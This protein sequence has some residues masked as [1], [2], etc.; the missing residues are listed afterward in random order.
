RQS[1]WVLERDCSMLAALA[2]IDDPP[3]PAW[4]RLFTFKPLLSR[5][6]TWQALFEKVR[7]R[8]QA[9][10][11]PFIAALPLYDWFE[12]LLYQSGFTQ[13]QAII[14]LEWCQKNT[15][16]SKPE[17]NFTIRPLLPQDLPYAHAV[18]CAA[19]DPLWRISIDTLTHAYH[20]SA[21]ATVAERE[22]KVLGFQISTAKTASAHLARLAVQPGQQQRGVGTFLLHNMQEHFNRQ[23]IND[24]TV[25][26]QN[27]NEASIALYQK[28][29]YKQTGERFPVM[30]YP[31][32]ADLAAAQK[33]LR[34][35]DTQR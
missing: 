26:T 15:S 31:I 6:E 30:V 9:D 20:H 24:L 17:A 1:F 21:Y 16:S 29:G 3:E 32:Q 2:C 18:D 19:F 7:Q 34:Q 27:D 25:N 4:V 22:G 10:H 13:R 11:L 23:G 14:G 33:S 28:L 12:H 5:S 35:A 8:L